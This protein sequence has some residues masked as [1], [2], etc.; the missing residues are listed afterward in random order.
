MSDQQYDNT[1]RGVLFKN[2]RKE[3]ER[4]PDYTGAI[5]IEGTDFWLSAW[6]QESKKGEKYL[7]LSLGAEKKPMGEESKATKD[8]DVPFDI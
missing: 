2:S 8:D 3:T 6:V 1:N 5:N 4:H 7:S